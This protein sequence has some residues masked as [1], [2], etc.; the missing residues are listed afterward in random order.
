MSAFAVVENGVSWFPV[1]ENVDCKFLYLSTIFGRIFGC[2]PRIG[3][4]G[5]GLPILWALSM[6][7]CKWFAI[8]LIIV[9]GLQCVTCFTNS[10]CFQRCRNVSQRCQPFSDR[11]IPWSQNGW[12]CCGTAAA[13]LETNMTAG[14][15]FA[16]SSSMLG[17]LT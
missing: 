10:G 5:N 17:L 12:R 15:F 16:P 14:S 7:Y 4:L 6:F 3:I 2:G 11:G 1:F 13:T 8:G 9:V